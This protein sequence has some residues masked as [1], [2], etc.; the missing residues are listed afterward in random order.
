[1]LSQDEVIQVNALQQISAADHEIDHRFSDATVDKLCTAYLTPNKQH[2]LM[3]DIWVCSTLYERQKTTAT[4]ATNSR[5][6][7][8]IFDSPKYKFKNCS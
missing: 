8:C 1:M 7:E 4:I 5:L 2:L 3:E 6:I